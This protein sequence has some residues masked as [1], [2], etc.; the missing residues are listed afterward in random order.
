MN[1]AVR[2]WPHERRSGSGQEQQRNPFHVQFFAV[3]ISAQCIGAIARRDAAPW[4]SLKG[5]LEEN[6]SPHSRMILRLEVPEP[7]ISSAVSCPD[8]NATSSPNSTLALRGFTLCKLVTTD[9]AIP[10]IASVTALNE[11]S[12]KATSSSPPSTVA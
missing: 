12:V 5:Y 1:L 3:S 9:S 6:Y 7:F 10:S 8:S 11:G 2:S 4:S